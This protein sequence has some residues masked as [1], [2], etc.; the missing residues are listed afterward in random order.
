MS[1]DLLRAL[2]IA[3]EFK[4]KLVLL[5][6]GYEY[7]VRKALNK[8]PIILPLAFPKVPEIEKPEQ[9][10]DYGLDELQHWDRAASNPARLVEA[11]IP[12]AFTTEK[13]E[14]PDKEF[15]SR[16]R[17]TVRRGLSKDAALAALTST[18]AEIF[19]VADRI[20]SIAPGRI[21]NLV[22]S[23]GD[24]FSDEAARILTTWV[25]G[26]FYETDAAANRDPRGTWEVVVDR[27]TLPLTIEGELDKPEAKLGGEKVAFSTKDDAVL[28]IA[29]AK[30]FDKG[31]G[32][33][34]FSGRLTGE[35]ISGSGDAPNE[36]KLAWTARRTSHLSPPRSRT[37]S[38]PRSIRRSIFLRAIPPAVSVEPP[39]RSNRPRC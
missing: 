10:L 16:I 39:H 25:D 23:S 21:A 24:L 14:K 37:K 38:H 18:P 17:L 15:W 26:K 34:R 11:G 30:L 9:A 6:N 35:A 28:L 32:A 33:V 12:I 5:G 27:K 19:G 3:D 7:R 29:P 31:E 2:R 36:I 8:T 1:F 22:V 20:G 13:L 4:L